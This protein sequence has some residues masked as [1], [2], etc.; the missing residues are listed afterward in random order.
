M[1]PRYGTL[2]I[3]DTLD[4]YNNT[5]VLAFGEEAMAGFIQL[6]L[7]A[8]NDYVADM[9][10]NLG[11]GNP[12]ER[13]TVYGVNSTSG[14]MIEVD[15][16]GLADAQKIPFSP[17][18]VGFPL[19]KYQYSLQ[20]TRDYLANVTPR[21]LANQ[22]LGIAEADERNFFNLI[23]R[24]LL[25]A[26]N[27]TA[28]LDRY[29]D[30]RNI[31]LRALV[32]ADSQAIPPNQVSLATFDASTH[33]HYL[34]TG[35]YVEANLLAAIET[36][37]EHGTDGGDIRVFI[38]AA[39]RATTAAFSTFQAYGDPRLVYST[40]ATRAQGQ[41]DNPLNLED[42]A[43]GFIGPAEVWVKPWVPAN[44]VIVTVVGGGG[45]PVLGWRRPDGANARY[46]GLAIAA[47]LDRFPLHAQTMQRMA[48]F[49]VWNRT[50]AA[51]L[52]TANATYASFTG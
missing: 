14:D 38:N 25:K 11:V 10:A 19:R 32:N 21:E 29:V 3:L 23:R 52:Y 22:T 48:G 18:S 12:P 13:E 44:Y 40:A 15:E 45:A 16:F 17:S 35:S 27:N 34:G 51:V 26:T 50:R 49:S 1:A 7:D 39:Q 2:S 5:N 8:Y 28:Y 9:T 24:T 46:A 42:Y 4:T 43:V 20:W 47:E 31:T 33:T 41:I 6:I 37:R 36:V 30:N